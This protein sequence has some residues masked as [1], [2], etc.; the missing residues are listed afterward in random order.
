MSSFI[1]SF[2]LSANQHLS[3]VPMSNTILNTGDKQRAEDS[4]LSS[5]CDTNQVTSGSKIRI[6][7][8]GQDRD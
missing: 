5:T 4:T 2:I 8:G 3:V 1:H 7:T 6:Q